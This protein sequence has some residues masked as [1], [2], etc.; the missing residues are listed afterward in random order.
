MIRWKG[1][2][3]NYW[4][5]EGNRIYSLSCFNLIKTYE[6]LNNKYLANSSTGVDI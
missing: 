5:S 6:K 4:I 1:E 2:S 3:G